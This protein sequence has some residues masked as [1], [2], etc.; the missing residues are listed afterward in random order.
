MIFKALVLG[1]LVYIAMLLEEINKNM[2]N[3]G[4]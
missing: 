2:K 4:K 1:L 3:D